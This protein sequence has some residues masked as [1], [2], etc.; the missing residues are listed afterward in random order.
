MSLVHLCTVS[1]SMGRRVSDSNSIRPPRQRMPKLPLN[2]F[3]S[4][5]MLCGLVFNA[6]GR[7]DDD[8][9]AKHAFFETRIRPILMQRR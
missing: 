9:A 3:F 4:A 6:S 1:S 7:A 5:A 2:Q 8:T